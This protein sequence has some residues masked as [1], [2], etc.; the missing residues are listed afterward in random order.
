MR[1]RRGIGLDSMSGCGFEV[2]KGEAA[3][4]VMA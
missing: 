2:G 1:A 3:A 4:G